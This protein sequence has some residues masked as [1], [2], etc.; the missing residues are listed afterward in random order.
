MTYK[1]SCSS[2]VMTG[3][4]QGQVIAPN[5]K[6][7]AIQNEQGNSLLFSIGTDQ[8]FYVTE[9]V[10]ATDVVSDRQNSPS[11]T[12]WKKS[13]LSSSLLDLFPAGTDMQVKTFEVAQDLSSG[14]Y[15]VAMAI[16][17]SGN[18]LLYL[19][20]SY[21]RSD[22]GSLVLEW[23]EIPFDAQGKSYDTIAINAIYV[24]QTAQLPLVVVDILPEGRTTI[25]RYY[26]DSSKAAQ[27]QYWYYY[28]LPFNMDSSSVD[29][30]AGRKYG[31]YIDGIYT[32][33]VVGGHFSVCYQPL[34]NESNPTQAGAVCEL[35]FGD[36]A[37]P[38]R[39]ASTPSISK[40]NTYTDLYVITD[41]GDL[42]V[43]TSDNQHNNSI[44]QK[45]LSSQLFVGAT[46]LFAYTVDSKVVVWGI[47]HNKEIFYT[48]SN[49]EL[50][51]W[52]IPLP[53][54]SGVELI[55]PYVNRV[56]GGN[57]YFADLGNNQ[58][59]KV[60]Q[61]PVTSC[62][63]SETVL[64]PVDPDQPSA[65]FDCYM[66]RLTVLDD[67]NTVAS[68]V[69]VNILA[70]SR[71]ATYINNH[72][73]VLDPSIPVTVET[74]EAGGIKVVQ[75]I[76]SLQGVGLIFQSE[77][78]QNLEVNPMDTSTAKIASLNTPESLKNAEVVSDAG[79]PT[80]SLVSGDLENSDYETAADSIQSLIDA[81]NNYNVPSNSSATSQ[82]KIAPS[83]FVY[84]PH[85]KVY[86]LH[87]AHHRTLQFSVVSDVG[88]SLEDLGNA[89]EVKAGDLCSWLKSATEY[90]IQIIEDTANKVWNF[91]VTIAGEVFTF[92]ID[93]VEK[94]VEALMT[95]LQA[96]G[97]L[98]KDLIQFVKFLFSWDDITLTKEV[99]KNSIKLYLDS[100]MSG[101]VAVEGS[102]ISTLSDIEGKINDWA[103]LP[104]T[105]GN[106]PI[107]AVQPSGTQDVYN[108]PNTYL[109]DYF[110]SNVGLGT[111]KKLDDFISSELESLLRTFVNALT[112][113][114]EVIQGLV[115]RLKEDLLDDDRYKTM[116]F[117]EILKTVS[118][119]V[120][121]ALV[122][123]TEV[124]LEALVSLIQGLYDSIMQ[125]FDTPI[126]I[127]VISDLLESIFGYEISLSL[128]DI[129]CYILAI[130]GTLVYKVLNNKAPFSEDD[131]TTE[132]LINSASLNDLVNYFGS[133]D[134]ETIDLS[135]EFYSDIQIPEGG[136]DT[137]YF[138]FHLASSV[139]A[140][141]YAVLKP[142]ND[143]DQGI[144]PLAVSTTLASTTKS[145]SFTAAGVFAKPYPIQDETVANLSSFI[146][147]SSVLSSLISGV[148]KKKKSMAIPAA[149][150]QGVVDIV[151]NMFSFVPLA[152]HFYE[153]VQQ[154]QNK[155]T[156]LAY[157]DDSARA[158]NYIAGIA[159]G[160]AA[161]DPEPDTSEIMALT[162]SVCSLINGGIQLGACG[163]DALIN[164]EG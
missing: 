150:A 124:M 159:G 128:L 28:A 85:A 114:S 105:V 24:L 68:G 30:C 103:D 154:D 67:T 33:G 55:S 99:M 1:I 21:S 104:D 134:P 17:V 35:L 5:Q 34:L 96:L 160:I 22:N 162:S 86:Q 82:S 83:S 110:T 157:L 12:G 48:E 7:Q 102:I 63:T 135:K 70:K 121:D 10:V 158:A 111:F 37:T 116:S 49:A 61:D 129:F 133:T 106:E 88:D 90:V 69:K 138:T 78:G 26:I 131:P 2:E 18:D 125:F 149:Y 127:P 59:R 60:S 76:E 93:C 50:S 29:L 84:S 144:T 148:A 107:T 75:K 74:D 155:F 122:E 39:I 120:A 62:W 118:A 136:K 100:C 8:V 65:N 101:L 72:Y 23:E 56:N 153:L 38:K 98:I 142:L 79:D 47:N 54:A 132:Q 13:D 41:E 140:L 9:E 19:A 143:A 73:Y 91:A 109:A 151:L 71:V 147:Y 130:P 112:E 44:G 146:V 20:T 6:F 119:I 57:T 31:E 141:V 94:A 81:Y 53:I 42:Y 137:I 66:T 115:T 92:V 139:G 46:D 156:A 27:G 43:F 32:C 163:V 4:L 14:K 40:G 87:V 52:S 25:E 15:S 11:K 95:V 80:G 64:L 161:V 51:E 45:L 3:Y 123:S 113:E 152:Y 97:T 36:P 108:T 16:T 126:W 145:L 77:D 164:L 58:L 117:V 89:I